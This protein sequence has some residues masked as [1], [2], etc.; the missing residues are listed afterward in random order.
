[1][2]TNNVSISMCTLDRC[3]VFCTYSCTCC[4]RRI[5]SDQR[6]FSSLIHNYRIVRKKYMYIMAYIITQ[7][8]AHSQHSQHAACEQRNRRGVQKVSLVYLSSSEDSSASVSSSISNCFSYF[9]YDSN[10]PGFLV[11]TAKLVTESFH[12]KLIAPQSTSSNMP[13]AQVFCQI[14]CT[15]ETWKNSAGILNR[16]PMNRASDAC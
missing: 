11:A 16:V 5:C 1:M 9:S 14:P 2:P 3:I 10:T 12:A 4:I 7:L 6:V 15:R 13:N 8:E